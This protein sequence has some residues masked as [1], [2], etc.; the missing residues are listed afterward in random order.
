[1]KRLPTEISTTSKSL[2]ER[3]ISCARVALD[4]PVAKLFDYAVPEGMRARVGDRITVPFGTRER[5]GVVVA[6][7][8]A[9]ELPAQ[10]VK[11]LAAI[12][13]DAP[14]LP[15]DWLELMRFLS[16]YYHRPFGETVIGALPP[17][18]RSVKPLPR[19]VLEGREAKPGARFVPNHRLTPQ[20]A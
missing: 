14:P 15:A 17:R 7:L 11:P 12:R 8:A 6:L 18:L 19:K 2:P 10:R 9:S 16:G 13:D 5:A 4:V 20:Q 1:M 3:K